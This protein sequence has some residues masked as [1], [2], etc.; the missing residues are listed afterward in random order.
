MATTPTAINFVPNYLGQLVTQT[1][2]G[3]TVGQVVRLSG[4]TYVLALA[5][6][7]TDAQSVGIVYSVP[8]VNT[9]VLSQVG[10]LFNIPSPL[11]PLTAGV[12]YYLSSVTPG[13]LQNTPGSVVLPLFYADTSTSGYFENSYPVGPSGGGGSGI[14]TSVITTNTSMVPNNRYICDNSAGTIQLQMPANFSVG[15][16]FIVTAVNTGNFTILQNNSQ[17]ILFGDDTTTPGLSGSITSTTPLGDSLTMC[18]WVA[19][20]ELVVEASMGNFTIA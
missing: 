18:A 10:K 19:N 2:H 11:A 1:A 9:F 6:N 15:S 16:I 20:V 8:S 7:T 17:S 5:D 12:L 13:L 4:G 14:T 3:F